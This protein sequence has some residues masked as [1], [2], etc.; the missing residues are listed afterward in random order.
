MSKY[1]FK[2]YIILKSGKE[3][4]GFLI[5]DNPS[6]IDMSQ[7]IKELQN[8]EFLSL[9]TEDRNNIIEV[10]KSEIAIYKIEVIKW[11]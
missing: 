7:K 2:I 10:L 4:E 5:S 1:K 9:T 3:I 11:L 6:Q 8:Y